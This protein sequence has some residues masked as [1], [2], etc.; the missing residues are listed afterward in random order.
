MALNRS[1]QRHQC[2]FAISFHSDHS[3]WRKTAVEI[4]RQSR[5]SCAKSLKNR[6]NEVYPH[7]SMAEPKSPSSCMC[8]MARVHWSQMQLLH[9]C[10]LLTWSHNQ[11]TTW[12]CPNL[13]K[14]ETTPNIVQ[15]CSCKYDV[16]S[17]SGWYN[18]LKTLKLKEQGEGFSWA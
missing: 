17:L 18:L 7:G 1:Y 6:M 12:S 2:M 5:F 13:S 14:V 9:C 4:Y 10:L 16:D 3:L 11:H 15:V 8:C